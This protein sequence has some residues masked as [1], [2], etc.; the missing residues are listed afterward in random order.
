LASSI[1]AFTVVDLAH[2]EGAERV[3]EVV[4]FSG[5]GGRGPRQL[6]AGALA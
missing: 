2:D 1:H 6:G 3:A 4:K 5:R